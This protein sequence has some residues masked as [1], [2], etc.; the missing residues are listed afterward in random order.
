M[1]LIFLIKAMQWFKVFR[2]HD[3][4]FSVRLVMYACISALVFWHEQLINSAL[5]LE[6]L[7][8]SVIKRECLWH[9][10]VVQHLLPWY[11][12]LNRY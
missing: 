3:A 1:N 2:H 11:I 12:S 8:L 6:N 9:I 5:R 10:L 7:D 4:I